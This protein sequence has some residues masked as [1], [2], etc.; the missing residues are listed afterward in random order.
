M[1]SRS[2]GIAT[3]QLEDAPDGEE[4]P[5]LKGRCDALDVGAATDHN[6]DGKVSF[7]SASGIPN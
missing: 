7:L 2:S 6:G 3:E 1:R 5:H 4:V